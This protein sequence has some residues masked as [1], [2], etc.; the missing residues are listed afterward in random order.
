MH[1][2]HRPLSGGLVMI[3]GEKG[4]FYEKDRDAT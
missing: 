2:L 4:G 1:E 3:L